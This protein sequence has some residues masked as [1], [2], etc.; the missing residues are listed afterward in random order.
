MKKIKYTL[1][2]LFGLI[3]AGCSNQI[4]PERE[5]QYSNEMSLNENY[6]LEE[7]IIAGNDPYYIEANQIDIDYAIENHKIV[8]LN[9]YANWCPT[10]KSENEDISELISENL[11]KDISIFR[12]NFRDSDTSE[13]EESLAKKYQ[14]ITQ[15]TKII[16][17]NGEMNQKTP[18][19]FTQ[20][21]YLELL[22]IN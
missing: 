10:C 20:E 9:F 14:V 17:I 2:I 1:I 16:Y 19:H 15:G 6:F 4:T 7:N 21:D 11:S 5:I 8:I 13:Y 3:L 18:K 22:N 12:V